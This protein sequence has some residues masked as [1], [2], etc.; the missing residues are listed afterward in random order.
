[1]RR[2]VALQPVGG[3]HGH[4]QVGHGIV[5]RARERQQVF[6]FRLP[7]QKLVQRNHFAGENA[8]P[9]RVVFAQLFPK[10]DFFQIASG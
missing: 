6:D 2:A 1:M 8:A 7:V 3:A 9:G 4:R 10:F 5:Q